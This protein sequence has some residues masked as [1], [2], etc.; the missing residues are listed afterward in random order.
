MAP[1]WAQ[2][3]NLV[4]KSVLGVFTLFCGWRA[5]IFFVEWCQDIYHRKP[6]RAMQDAI[7]TPGSGK[8][9]EALMLL[10]MKTP[11]IAQATGL[12]E[13]EVYKSLLYWERK[14]KIKQYPFGWISLERNPGEEKPKPR[15]SDGGRFA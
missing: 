4:W 11:Q 14:G 15:R 8:D 13:S 9:I 3:F 2:E 6:L 1:R 7:R 12:P 10:P 5:A